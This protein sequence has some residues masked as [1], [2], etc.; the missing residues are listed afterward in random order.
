MK[1][2]PDYDPILHT[3]TRKIRTPI[4]DNL[5]EYKQIANEMYEF[6]IEHNGIGLAANQVGLDLR[7]FVMHKD[8]CDDWLF[9][10]PILINYNNKIQEIEEGCLTFPGEQAKV[11]RPIE[12]TVKFT[13]IDNTVKTMKL[14]SV[15]A[16]CWQ[17]E[18]D[19][20]NGITMYDRQQEQQ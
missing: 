6:M 10:N 8:L 12:I 17:H 16:R 18:F 1:L 11:K 2:Y 9:I 5:S 13:T 4:L 7:M 20:L 19:H 14:D 3:K 15:A